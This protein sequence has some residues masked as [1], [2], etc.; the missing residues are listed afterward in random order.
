MESAMHNDLAWA[1][2]GVEPGIQKI[3]EGSAAEQGLSIGQWLELMIAGSR[4]VEANASRASEQ[5]REMCQVVVDMAESLVSAARL[6]G[7][8]TPIPE[9]KA[10]A[11]EPELVADPAP[12]IVPRV[13]EG[14]VP[15]VEE[16]QVW[17]RALDEKKAGQARSESK[18]SEFRRGLLRLSA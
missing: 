7:L 18:L 8:E 12:A 16:L 14:E 5:R 4:A 11:A 10:R 2:L 9:V 15:K 13:A 3:V 17:M 6:L 1:V